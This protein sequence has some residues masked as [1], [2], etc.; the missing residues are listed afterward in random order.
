METGA[1]YSLPLASLAEFRSSRLSETLPQKKRWRG[2]EV[3]MSVHPRPT[4]V[5]EF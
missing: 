3:L 4:H 1:A 2:T 5:Q